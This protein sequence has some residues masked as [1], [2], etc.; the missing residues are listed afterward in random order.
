MLRNFILDWSGTLADVREPAESLP[1]VGEFLH[2]CRSTHRRVFLL[3]SIDDPHFVEQSERL[4]VTH[5]FERSY[6]GAAGKG[7][8]MEEILAENQLNPNET[9]FVGSMVQDMEMAKD[10]GVTAIATLGGVD[11]R[12]NLGRANPDVMVRDL[13]E[14]W[15]LLESVPPHDEI[16]IEDLEL[17]A[18][19]GVPDEER[20]QP[21]RLALSLLLQPR[22]RFSELGDDLART[23]NYAAVCEEVR[24]FVA[25]RQDKLIETLAHQLAE[26]LLG[27]FDLARVEL[28]VRKFV[29][30]ET[31]HVA[32]RVARAR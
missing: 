17:K 13:G 28:E 3:S 23:I 30:P 18:R 11:L 5:F 25:G 19:V 8:R 31:R 15:K 2:F 16:R 12:E 26:H 6:V 7:D 20:A 22:N 9:A 4:D 27:C 32:V 29:L 10:A 21:Q 24:G 1:H 14:L